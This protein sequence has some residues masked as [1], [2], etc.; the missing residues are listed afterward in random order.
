MSRHPNSFVACQ[1]GECYYLG[2]DSDL[3]GAQSAAGNTASDRVGA[4][5]TNSTS[6]IQMQLEGPSVWVTTDLVTDCCNVIIIKIQNFHVVFAAL[7]AKARQLTAD[8]R[9]SELCISAVASSD[10]EPNNLSR[11]IG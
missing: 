4:F 6:V 11:S 8:L 5:A 1:A 9:I 2:Y 10:L 3:Y 7:A